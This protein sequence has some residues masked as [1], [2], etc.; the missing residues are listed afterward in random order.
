MACDTDALTFQVGI[1]GALLAWVY[2]A[3]LFLLRIKMFVQLMSKFV[4]PEICKK[5]TVCCEIIISANKL[6]QSVKQI[7]KFNLSNMEL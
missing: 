6:L 2:I 4:L 3:G 5:I 7:G 1:A